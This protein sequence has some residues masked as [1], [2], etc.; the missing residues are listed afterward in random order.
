MYEHLKS[1]IE[2]HN[3]HYEKLNDDVHHLESLMNEHYDEL[4][5]AKHR[6]WQFIHDYA[7]FLADYLWKYKL[8][9]TAKDLSALD[10]V[11]YA[12]WR[13]MSQ[14]S[15][16]IVQMIEKLYKGEEQNDR[17][18]NFSIQSDRRRLYS[19]DVLRFVSVESIDRML[20]LRRK[21]SN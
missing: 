12:V 7:A 15:E 5:I 11:P 10:L 6:R 17:T 13:K 3:A 4:E 8:N 9:L 2:S 21:D 19:S 18:Y 1:M 16:M 20:E 14:K